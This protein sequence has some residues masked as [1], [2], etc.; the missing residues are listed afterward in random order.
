ME[1]KALQSL[2]QRISLEYFNKPFLHQAVFNN[3]LRTTGGRYMLQ[4]H[5]IEI[6]M[7]QFEAYGEE[8]IIDIIKHELVHYHLHIEGKGY[9]HRD[10]DFKQLAQQVG[11]PRFCNPLPD[12]HFKYLYTCK[13]CNNEFLRKRR[14]SIHKYRCKCGGHLK[15]ILN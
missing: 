10:R 2:V 7:K 5:N 14:M 6:S 9:K 8:A 3:R 12:V 11:A 13:S 4:N 1:N 15:E